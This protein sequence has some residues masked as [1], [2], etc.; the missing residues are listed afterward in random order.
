MGS[1]PAGGE[2][3]PQGTRLALGR[4]CRSVGRG[5]RLGASEG[6]VE[7]T[8]AICCDRGLSRGEGG[9]ERAE[10]LGFCH[11]P[12]VRTQAVWGQHQGLVPGVY[13][14]GR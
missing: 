1:A 2:A 11:H 10:D 14:W 12:E 9:R 13:L 7:D 4:G 3:R 8:V 5:R 6:R